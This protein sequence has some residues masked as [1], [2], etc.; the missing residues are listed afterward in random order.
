MDLALG[1]LQWLICRKNK[2]N[3][4]KPNQTCVFYFAVNKTH[5]VFYLITEYYDCLKY[6]LNK[7]D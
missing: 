1:N 4:T 7:L 5:I 3:Q 2:P 6:A